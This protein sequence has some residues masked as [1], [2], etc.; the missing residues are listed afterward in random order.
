MHEHRG[1]V[2]EVRPEMRFDEVIKKYGYPIVSKEIAHKMHDVR[3]AEKNGRVNSYAVR[4]LNGT[5]ISKNGKTGNS[6]TKWK[7][8]L[9][10]PFSISHKCCDVMKKNPASTF[11]RETGRKPITGTMASE[12]QTR[13]LS[14]IKHGCNAFDK[15]RPSSQP[16]SFWKESDVL[17]YIKRYEVPICS[18]YGSI[19]GDIANPKE[20]TTS[21]LRRTG[22]IFCGFGC[23]FDKTP[24]RFQL[25]KETHP[26]QYDYCINGGEYNEEGQWQPS[27]DGLGLGKVLD[28]IG[29]PYE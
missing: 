2:I 21:K 22:C 29:V 10:A 26:R 3:T 18:V 5:Y 28:Y 15:G 8:L 1:G 17:E 14:W 19:D 9:N 12:S 25:L 7:F 4:K 23:S 6:C 11:E 16:M 13:G 27:K 20:L 24:N